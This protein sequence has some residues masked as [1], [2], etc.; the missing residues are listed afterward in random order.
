MSFLA[1]Q[2]LFFSDGHVSI[3]YK[4]VGDDDRRSGSERY[5]RATRLDCQ[6]ST[7]IIRNHHSDFVD[8]SDGWSNFASA[9]RFHINT[10]RY[11]WLLAMWTSF[12]Q[13]PRIVFWKLRY[14]GLLGKKMRLFT[15]SIIFLAK[16]LHWSTS[17]IWTIWRL[18]W[19]VWTS[20]P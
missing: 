13:V 4:N 20:S 19:N 16:L 3:V 17:F 2:H 1:E 15:N 6:P 11:H 12:A 5:S 14:S 10:F 8:E 7:H 18:R 9:D